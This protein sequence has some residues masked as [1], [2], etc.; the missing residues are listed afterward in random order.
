MTTF[1]KILL[2][3]RPV[4]SMINPTNNLDRGYV[5]KSTIVPCNDNEYAEK[6]K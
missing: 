1:E 3:S 5:F 4:G 6:G 2:T